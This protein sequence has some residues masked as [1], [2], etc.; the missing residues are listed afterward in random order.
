MST[1]DCLQPFQVKTDDSNF[2]DDYCLTQV[3]NEDNYYL[4]AFSS[5]KISGFQKI[6]AA[7]E[8]EVCAVLFALRKFD[9]WLHYNSVEFITEHNPLMVETTLKLTRCVLGLQRWN[10]TL[11]QRPGASHQG[12]DKLSHL[13]K[14]LI[15]NKEYYIFLYFL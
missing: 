8:K 6:W 2:A 10:Y 9:K 13:K 5:Q 1:P 4:I 12:T 14:R 15:F 3:D 7:I 11:S